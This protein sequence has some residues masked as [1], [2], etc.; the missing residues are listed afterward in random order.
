VYRGRQLFELR[1]LA[2]SIP[3]PPAFLRMQGHY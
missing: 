2:A 1:N 3:P